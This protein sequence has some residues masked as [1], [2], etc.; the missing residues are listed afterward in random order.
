MESIGK[1]SGLA[2]FPNEDTLLNIVNYSQYHI[3]S[4]VRQHESDVGFLLTSF[5]GRP[6][7]SERLASWE[8]LDKINQEKALPWC[9]IGDSNEIVTQDEN[10]GVV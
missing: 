9:I 10:L 1:S 4:K 6:N 8:L 7:V 2:L 5:Y 3:H